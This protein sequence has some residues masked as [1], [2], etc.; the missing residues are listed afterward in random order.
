[1]RVAVTLLLGAALLVLTAVSGRADP[2]AGEQ[3]FQSNG[4]LG[5]HYTDGPAKEQTIADQ[6]AKKGPELWYAGSKLQRPWLEA[7]LQDPQPIRPMKYNSL[8]ER[9]TGDHPK[10]AAGDAADVADYLMTL[11]SADVE[12]GIIKP[13]KNPVARLIFSKKVLCSGC[14]QYPARKKVSGGRN[15]PS[16]VGAGERLNPDWI[17]AYLMKPEVFKP[18][19]AMPVF[20]GFLSPKDMNELA[21]YIANFK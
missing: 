7:W 4:C 2:A 1:M 3:A 12:A 13:E 15:G 16:L 6:L 18:I 17:F 8:T 9:N 20:A 11:T 5:C 21:A 10:L 19:T 14:H